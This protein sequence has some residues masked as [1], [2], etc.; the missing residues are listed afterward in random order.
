MEWYLP[1]IWALVIG[2]AVAMYVVLDGFD[3]GIGI[4]FPFA[5]N[6]RSRD[7]MMNT[8]APFWDGNET[9]LVLGGVG[10]FVAFP[11]AYAILMPAFYLPVTLMLLGLVL[12]GVSFEFR[13]I[14]KTS[15]FLWNIAFALGSTVAAFMQGVIVG[16]MVTGVKTQAMQF[17]GG[18]FDWL[19]PFALMCG[20]AMVAGYALLGATWLIMKTEGEVAQ[21]A[22]SQAMLALYAVLFFM[23]IVSLWTPLEHPRIAE[24][25]FTLPNFLFFWPVPVVTAILSFLC[26]HWL[27]NN[28][29]FMPFWCSIALFFMGY[30]GLVI[31]NFPYLVPPSLDVWQTAGVPASQ[32]FALMGTLFMFPILVGYTIFIYWIFRGK[33]REGEGYH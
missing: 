22:R 7:Q 18:S 2:F 20:L 9:W 4:L 26:W 16:G 12:R 19:T 25:W 15:R 14:A 31:S 32:L 21:R 24:R 23:A 10:L 1:L 3:L 29:Q 11:A 13:W 6:E 17:A 8:V 33:I 30:S 27:R 28:N 5:K